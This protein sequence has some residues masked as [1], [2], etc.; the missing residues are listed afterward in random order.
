MSKPQVGKR[1][2]VIR[3]LLIAVVV[4]IG[5]SLFTVMTICNRT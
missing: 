2:G 3:M 5:A 1:M 4:V